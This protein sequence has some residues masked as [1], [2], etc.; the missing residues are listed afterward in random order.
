MSL[1]SSDAAKWVAT[2]MHRR[3]TT[4]WSDKEVRQFRILLK[5]GC[6][7]NSD[8]LKLL[9]QYYFAE[10]RKGDNGCHRRDLYTFVNNFAGELD[11]AN[12]WRVQHP[13]KREPSKIIQMPPVRSGEPLTLST[14]DAEA[15]LRFNAER[16]KR[17]LKP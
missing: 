2:L 12:L 17:K 5:Q 3:L 11:R 14:E 13:L 8:D 1:P 7:T 9:E 4:H 15:I 6:F 16:E 10:R